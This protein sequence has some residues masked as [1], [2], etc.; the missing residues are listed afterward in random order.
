MLLA[1]RSALAATVSD[2]FV[3][4]LVGMNDA[5]A[6]NKFAMPWALPIAICNTGRGVI[7]HHA[8]A[9]RMAV[10]ELDVL[11]EECHSAAVEP[12]FEELSKMS[13]AVSELILDRVLN[14]DAVDLVVVKNDPVF[15]VRHILNEAYKY[16]STTAL[17]DRHQSRG[18]E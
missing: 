7:A 5:S 8:S 3:A 6:M 18:A 1:T 13:H 14:P 11:G 16:G 10:V 9:A 15:R 17:L 2:G 4:A 12:L